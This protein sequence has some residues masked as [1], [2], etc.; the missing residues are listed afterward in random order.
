MN[1][2]RYFS[3]YHQFSPGEQEIQVYS[4]RALEDRHK[5]SARFPIYVTLSRE[6]IDFSV[7]YFRDEEEN[8]SPA[9]LHTTFLSLPLMM[10]A[11]K[12]DR[13]VYTLGEVYDTPYPP[14][15]A[16]HSSN[17]DYLYDL[18]NQLKEG[19][20]SILDRVE[21]ILPSEVLSYS[22]LDAFGVYDADGNM[23]NDERGKAKVSFIRKIILDFLFDLK[24]THVFQTSRY[25]HSIYDYLLGHYFLDSLLKKADFYYYRHLL[26]Q[27]FNRR[28]PAR[29][30]FY[31]E[32]LLRAEAEWT[33][34]IRNPASD[35]VF[36]AS[37]GWFDSPEEEM[38]K[39]YLAA[40]RSKESTLYSE[41][42][43]D[44]SLLKASYLMSSKWYMRRYAL[45]NLFRI[46]FPGISRSAGQMLLF[47]GLLFYFSRLM[48]WPYLCSFLSVFL[49]LLCVVVTLDFWNVK[50]LKSV[51]RFWGIHVFI[52][53]L[54]IAIVAGWVTIT[55][56]SD[57]LGFDV[58][59]GS[60]T[61]FASFLKN[62]G[63]RFWALMACLMAS[64][65]ILVFYQTGKFNPYG[66]GRTRSGLKIRK[67]Y[68][69]KYLWSKFKK[70]VVLLLIGWI[71][72]FSIGLFLF[73]LFDQ[74]ET[75]LTNLF[76]LP[77]RKEMLLYTFFAQFIG[78]FIQLTFEEK[79][80]TE[81][82]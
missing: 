82:L 71:Y 22:E 78:V 68:Y 76:C 3:V 37:G 38:N 61:P 43:E 35:E 15:S 49:G 30:E 14:R 59:A 79:P 6:N 53:R 13:L 10:H 39:I 2:G 67:K 56:G 12:I 57:M 26:T 52:P 63:N 60:V 41:R 45:P 50:E 48:T 80:M 75:F 1:Y 5:A 9:H 8:H 58:P 51:S 17:W 7:H 23:V 4:Y 62:R 74:K 24:H 34:A 73:S 21:V 29:E 25:Y 72:S 66:Q 77:V 31:A 36:S 46:L 16:S 64:M 44:T 65:L 27:C 32:Q 28:E 11:E 20:E 54:F 42:L 18:V 69:K 55:L 19:A 81:E 70:S 33:E 40:G 47:L